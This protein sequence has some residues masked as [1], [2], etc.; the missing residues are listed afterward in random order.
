MERPKLAT[1]LP[2]KRKKNQAKQA[3]RNG[4]ASDR[5]A[6][7]LE[8]LFARAHGAPNETHGSVLG[9]NPWVPFGFKSV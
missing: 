6:D 8:D 2:I 5:T 3:G 7:L 4:G 1:E 9:L